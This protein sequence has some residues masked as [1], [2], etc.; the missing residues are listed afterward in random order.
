MRIVFLGPLPPIRG[1]IAAHTEGAIE[2]L[3]GCGHEVLA[4]SY[5]RLY[6]RFVA[7][8]RPGSGSQP[9]SLGADRTVD[10]LSPRTWLRAAATAR[11]FAPDVVIAQY[12]TP[13]AAAAIRVVLSRAGTAKRVVVCH[14]VLPHERIP[15]GLGV[16]R[17]LLRRCDGVIFHS[18]HVMDRAAVLGCRSPSAVARVPLLIGGGEAEGR[19]LPELMEAWQGGARLFVCAG[20]VRKYKGLGILAAA[21]RRAAPAGDALLVVAGEQ[22]GARCDLR[23]LRRLG[24]QIRVIPRYLDDGELTWLLRHAEAVFLPYI[25]ASQSGLLPAAMRL[26]CHV[27]VSNAG[28]LA[29]DSSVGR[30]ANLTTV[31]AGD[32]GALAASIGQLSMRPVSRVES[33]PD[34]ALRHAAAPISA[35]ERRESW[36]SFVAALESVLATAVRPRASNSPGLGSSESGVGVPGREPSSFAWYDARRAE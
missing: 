4:I 12:W 9:F 27:V 5:D 33:H 24:A 32:I 30:A 20:H 34:G 26:A 23:A 10:C 21:W 17:W 19:P 18:R 31:P 11:A 36:A 8:R 13:I 7:G 28:G 22:F 14:N 25:S 35:R 6:P 3:R 1:G 29:E 15:G 2:A 16:A